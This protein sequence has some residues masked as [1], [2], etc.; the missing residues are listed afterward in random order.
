MTKE[1]KKVFDIWWRLLRPHTLSAAFIPV[2]IGTVLALEITSIHFG[3]FGA[4]LLASIL[5]QA[6]TNMFNEYFD[7][8]RGL[9]TKD[10]IGIGGTIVRDKV[11]PEIVLNLAFIFLG[12]ATL[13]GVYICMMSSW[14]LAVVGLI[15]MSVGYLYTG[16]PYPI[17]YT[18]FGELVSG[19]FMGLLIISISFF[20]QTDMVN[21]K[22]ILIS[23]PTSILIGAI[24]MANNLRD[25]DGDKEKGRRT[26]VIILGKINGIRF[27]TGMFV[28]TYVFLLLLIFLNF[29]SWWSMLVVLTIPTAIKAVKGFIGKSKPIEMMPAMKLTA[30][31]NIQF[32]FL[33]GLSIIISHYI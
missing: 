25:F 31:T 9:D 29:A 23:V 14:W 27:F 28:A 22:T 5:I 33:L 21:L 6:A 19:L 15:S 16:G 8:K 11:K 32:G 17:A 30:K 3:L 2:F 26:L 1:Q 10:S 13:L 7:F 24:L 12:V 20:I 4:M 18:P